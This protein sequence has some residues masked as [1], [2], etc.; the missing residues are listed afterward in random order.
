M[1][2]TMEH[3]TKKI[4]MFKSAPAIRLDVQFTEVEKTAIERSG[5]ARFEF[6]TPPIHSH[7]EAE[8][9]RP[10]RIAHLLNP[11]ATHIV[12]QDQATARI[13]DPKIRQGL[14][15]VKAAIEENSAPVPIKDTFEL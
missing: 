6:Y 1:Q 4:S 13:E 14:K 7:Y 10:W 12:F 2:V 15:N 11:K 3:T 5:L 8:Y 9:Q